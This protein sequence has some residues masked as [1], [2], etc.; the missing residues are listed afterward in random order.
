MTE[1]V[2]ATIGHKS[3]I[4]DEEDTNNDDSNTNDAD[5]EMIQN[6]GD[7][8]NIENI[9]NATLMVNEDVI[10]NF[11]SNDVQV[12]SNGFEWTPTD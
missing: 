6:F 1:G 3:N 8:E 10:Q 7:D 4:I 12:A 11:G 2:A 5:Q 9:G